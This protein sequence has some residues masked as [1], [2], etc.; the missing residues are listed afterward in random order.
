MPDSS[1]SK[2]S[3]TKMR[4]RQRHFNPRDLGASL[5]LDARFISQGNGTAIS[6]WPD[7]S[8][9]AYNAVQAT[10]GKQPTFETAGVSGQGA[11][12][13]DGGDVLDIASGY[14][15]LM[16][17]NNSFTLIVLTNLSSY[18]SSPVIFGKSPE[19]FLEFGTMASVVYYVGSSASFRT[20]GTA[21]PTLAT[22]SS[23]IINF[24]RTGATTGNIFT[25]GTQQTS[26]TNSGGGLQSQASASGSLFVGGYTVAPSFPATGY[27]PAVFFFKDDLTA[28]QRKRSEHAIACSWKIACN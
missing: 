2:S 28:A 22:N 25:N 10:G 19:F 4:A 13:F 23:Y 15:N 26:F 8:G 12:K 5:V 20:Y 11:V 21:N 27:I 6:S 7:R 14:T 1:A 9:N 24:A 17:G 3:S 16:S 18:A